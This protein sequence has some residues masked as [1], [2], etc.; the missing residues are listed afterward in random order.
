M[1]C[2]GNREKLLFTALDAALNRKKMLEAVKRS[3]GEVPS[4]MLAKAEADLSRARRNAHEYCG[5]DTA[6]AL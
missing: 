4:R 2:P 5:S 1:D 3:S 6:S